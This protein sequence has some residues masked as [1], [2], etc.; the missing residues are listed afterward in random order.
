MIGHTHLVDES[1]LI[2]FGHGSVTRPTLL[3][4]QCQQ[5]KGQIP[6]LVS[7]ISYCSGFANTASYQKLEGEKTWEKVK[8]MSTRYKASF[9]CVPCRRCRQIWR[10]FQWSKYHTSSWWVQSVHL[11][12][13]GRRMQCVEIADFSTWGGDRRIEWGEGGGNGEM[14]KMEAIGGEG[15]GGK[16][17]S[18]LSC[19][20]TNYKNCSFK[21]CPKFHN[22]VLP[23]TCLS[24]SP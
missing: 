6:S 2:L 10:C 8:I 14:E 12:Q 17:A 20:T 21:L 1:W 5:V 13:S 16:F 3:V 9:R 22:S 23:M 7:L 24:R 11:E 18:S 19:I 4:L 15:M